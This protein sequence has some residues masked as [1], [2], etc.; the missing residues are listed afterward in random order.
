[1]DLSSRLDG[2]AV[3]GMP[4]IRT[5][6]SDDGA[7]RAVAAEVLRPVDFDDPGNTE[8]GSDA[9]APLLTLVDD[10]AFAGVTGPDLGTAYAAGSPEFGYALL[11]DARSMA[12]AGTGGEITVELVDLS[13]S[14]PEEADLLESFMGRT[15]RCAAVE[16]GAV[17]ANLSI[18]NMDFHEFADLVGED[19]VHRGFDR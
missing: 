7:W 13:C 5:D 3:S 12:E 2:A 15:F 6:F 14:D 18:A 8:P 19:G 11:A 4:L 10:R 17:E 1:M 9:Y 16:V